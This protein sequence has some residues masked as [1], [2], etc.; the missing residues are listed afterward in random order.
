[1]VFNLNNRTT[2]LV[3]R[4]A[5]ALAL[6]TGGGSASA[7]PIHVSIDTSQF[8][9]ASGYIDMEFSAIGGAPLATAVVTN[10]AGFAASPP[11]IQW[12]VEQFADG[13]IFRNDAVNLL[14]LAANFGGVASFDLD[15][16]GTYDPTTSFVS[17]FKVAA[18]DGASYLGNFD[19]ATGALATFLWTPS[20]TANNNGGGLSVVVADPTVTVV[21]EPSD[22]LLMGLGLAAMLW[23]HR[24]R[25]RHAGSD[26]SKGTAALP[27]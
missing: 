22:L 23:V 19:P 15:I 8:G 2:R 13:F 14:S 21:P 20:A 26:M 7:A 16:S 6:A 18:F 11:D 4:L 5:L 3:Q 17:A 12:N 10:L 27:A 9:V 25:R 1:M 24:Q